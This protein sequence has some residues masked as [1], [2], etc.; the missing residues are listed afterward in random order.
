M[1]DGYARERVVQ[2]GQT[3]GDLVEIK[4]GIAADEVVAT[5]NLE[6]LSE[7]VAVRQ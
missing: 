4:S 3:E 1:R 6:L 5:S 2:V 7:G